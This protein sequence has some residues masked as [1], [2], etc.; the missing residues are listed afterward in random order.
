MKTALTMTTKY[1]K[2]AFTLIEMMI[3]IT[4]LTGVFT[5][6]Y[7]GFS[8]M[9]SSVKAQ[10]LEKDISTINSSIKVYIAHGGEIGTLTSPQSIID[11]LKTV[12][13]ADNR[14]QVVGLRGSMVDPRLE[15]VMQTVAEAET[16]KPRASWN[17]AQ[18]RF[19]VVRD[20]DPGIEGFKMNE[21]RILTTP[22]FEN[23]NV[24]LKFAKNG[25][26]VWD[27]IDTD[28]GNPGSVGLVNVGSTSSIPFGLPN[29]PAAP[30]A[31][32]PPSF[33]AVGGTYPLTDYDDFAVTLSDP[34]PAGSS[35]VF[36]TED[37]ANWLLYQGESFTLSPDDIIGA[38]AV[39]LDPDSW[40]D[41]PIQTNT[42]S[43]QP[44]QLAIDLAIP[45]NPVTYAEVGGAMVGGAASLVGPITIT[46]SNFDEVP[47]RYQNSD[48]FNIVWS[49]DGSDR[50]A[51]RRSRR[52][53]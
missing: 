50:S 39:T 23:R 10:K 48:T 7:T 22:I 46:L 47:N 16:D 13:T 24:S 2:R 4:A 1:S 38:I 36:Y 19:E 35:Q 25:T 31:L 8:E 52:S 44:V 40:A 28:N 5:I 45:K 32:N 11:K 20:G 9:S 14:K 18:Q 41:S 42:Y 33:S 15:V 37:G 49:Y 3:T 12:P 30:L 29:T 17:S 21:A 53:R 51:S 43:A 27:Y 26:W 34:N 6:G